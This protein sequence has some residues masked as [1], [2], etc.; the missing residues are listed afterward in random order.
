MDEC[1]TGK[2]HNMTK[3]LSQSDRVLIEK[4]LDDDMTFT[5][6]S[7]RIGRSVSTVSREIRNHRTFTGDYDRLYPNGCAHYQSCITRNLCPTESIYSCR[8]RCKFCKEY[9]C[10]TLCDRFDPAECP[11]LD[12]PPYVCNGCPK[13]RSCKK[14]H[15]YYSAQSAHHNYLERLSSSR[16][17]VRI[18]QEEIIRLDEILAPLILKGQS[19]NHIFTSHKDEI[20]YCE[21]TIYNYIDLNVF[22]F[23]NIDLPKKVRYRIRHPQKVATKLEYEYR[24]GRTIDCFHAFINAHPALPITE[25]D[26]VKGARH[27]SKKTLLTLIMRQTNFMLVFLLPDGTQRSVLDVFDFLFEGLGPTAFLKL[28]AVILTDNGVEFKCPHDLEFTP[29]GI[30]RTRI[31]YCDP[32]AS[33]QKPHVEKNHTLIRRILPKGTPFSFLTDDHVHL[34]TRHINSVPREA[35]DNR[36]PFDLMTS[37]EQKKLLE[38]LKLSPIPLDDVLLKPILLKKK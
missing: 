26:T 37:P 34:I 21:K 33:W 9:D 30:R 7:R 2:D 27:S 32:Q 36:T 8:H 23:R 5:Y 31:F 35:F 6:I 14:I 13:D 25:M 15:A 20:G 1:L 19:I 4:Y 22:S 11:A 18:T 12:L 24:K 16:E 29:S 3:H 28:F 10:T 38:F 17:G